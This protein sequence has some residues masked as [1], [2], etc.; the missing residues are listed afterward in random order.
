MFLSCKLSTQN[1]SSIRGSASFQ[2]GQKPPPPCHRD[3]RPLSA[4]DPGASTHP[5]VTVPHAALSQHMG[6][7]P[8]LSMIP[9]VML[10]GN[11]EKKK[12]P[13]YVNTRAAL[14]SPVEGMGLV[15][16]PHRSPGGSQRGRHWLQSAVHTSK[17]S[18]INAGCVQRCWLK[19]KV[20]MLRN[21]IWILVSP[22]TESK[23]VRIVG[24]SFKKKIKT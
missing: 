16:L 20:L 7:S 4:P 15:S 22:S 14:W 10:A 5:E 1:V 6:P 17:D 13:V 8:C 23:N 12:P 11:C 9:W 3:S 19:K 24:P 18:A 2:G 21:S